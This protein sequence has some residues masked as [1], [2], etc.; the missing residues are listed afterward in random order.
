MFFR[1]STIVSDSLR[2]LFLL[3][4]VSGRLSA[5]ASEPSSIPAQ[6]ANVWIKR[7]PLPDAPVSPRLGYEGACVW[8]RRQQLLVRYGGHNQGG[9][10]EQG[11]EVWTFDLATAKWTLKEPNTSPPGVCCNGDGPAQGAS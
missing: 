9:G 11:A 1:N 10:G 7:T 6:P 8:D 2:L 3:V 5:P 4:L